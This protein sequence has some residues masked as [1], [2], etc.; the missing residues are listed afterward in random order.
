MRR[1]IGMT[2]RYWL[3]T[4]CYLAGGMAIGVAVAWGISDRRAPEYTRTAIAAYERR[5][6]H[7]E[8]TEER[9]SGGCAVAFYDAQ[10]DAAWAE[11]MALMD[12][13]RMGSELHERIDESISVPGWARASL[14]SQ[15]GPWISKRPRQGMLVT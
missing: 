10:D 15:M 14:D 9:K 5:G 2:R 4:V 11:S 1:A 8:V 7:Y 6:L 12:R 13:K 3:V